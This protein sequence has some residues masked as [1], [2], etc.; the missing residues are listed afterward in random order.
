[1]GTYT[2]GFE[3]LRNEINGRLE[4]LEGDFDLK[5][6]R[7]AL[8]LVEKDWIRRLGVLAKKK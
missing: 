1:M 2:Y 7:L 8:K 3:E 5:E 6:L 4:E